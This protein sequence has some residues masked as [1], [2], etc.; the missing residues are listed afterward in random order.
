MDALERRLRAKIGGSATQDSGKEGS[1]HE[2]SRK[3]Q[4]AG[5]SVR[6][7][8][9]GAKNP[10]EEAESDVSEEER[11]D[12]GGRTGAFAKKYRGQ[13]VLEVVQTAK[14]KKRKKKKKDE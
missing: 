9:D 6:D 5:G 7:G 13:P 12:R 11:E 14:K 8:T 4:R 3:K 10:A 2:P 1:N